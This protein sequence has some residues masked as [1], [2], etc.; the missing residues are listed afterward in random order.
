VSVALKPGSWTNRNAIAKR[1]IAPMVTRPTRHALVASVA[2]L[3]FFADFASRYPDSMAGMS[4][5]TVSQQ[6][7]HVR[8]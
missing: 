1:E 2:T 8:L 5:L 3:L 4:H 7:V 6:S